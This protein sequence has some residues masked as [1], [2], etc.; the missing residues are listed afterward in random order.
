MLK[1]DKII[2]SYSGG[3]DTSVMLSWLKEK[4]PKSQLI[5]FYADIGQ[6][7]D[8]KLVEERAYKAGADMVIIKDLKEEFV[9]NYIFKALMAGAVY[10]GEYYLSTALSRP[11][12]AKE[13]VK[14]AKELGAS[15]IAHGATAKG[16]DQLRFE[17]SIHILNP[18]IEVLAPARLWE[19]KS[20]EEEIDYALRKNIPIEIT[21]KAPYSIDKNLWG[22][23]IECAELENPNVEPKEEAYQLTKSPKIA[24]DREIYINIYFK[25]GI[26]IKLN[27]Q[28]KDH[29]ELIT[30]LNEL[31]KESGIGRVDMIEDRVVGL[32]S[33]EVYEAPAAMIL[34]KAHKDLE[35]I[36]LDRDTI[37]F[38]QIVALKYAQLI[39]D[40]LWYSRLKD[41]LDNFIS[42]TQRFVEGEVYLKLYKGNV[43]VVGRTSSFS[44]YKKELI[45]Y[46][47][48]S[49]FKPSWAEGFIKFSQLPYSY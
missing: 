34:Y 8:K 17:L 45:S 42:T 22:V 44:L 33:R 32:K 16:N 18:K 25:Q 21:K 43:I 3:L 11:L 27:N 20:R 29:V 15:K 40:G 2:L 13:L 7:E 23:S 10:E 39:Y 37:N 14:L 47:G 30:K 26:P 49:E 38:K 24:Q 19:F 28:Q 31:G 12:I 9:K 4:Y 48:L 5:A 1:E 6:G 46:S 35:S 41:A 36:T